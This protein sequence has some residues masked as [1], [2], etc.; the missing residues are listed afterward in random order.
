M[1]GLAGVRDGVEDPA[2]DA[3]PHVVGADV[4]GRGRAWALDRGSTRESA[5]PYRSCPAWSHARSSSVTSRPRPSRRSTIPPAPN[6]SIGR[7]VRGVDREQ[8]RSDREEEARLGAVAGVPVDHPAIDAR[9]PRALGV[10]RKRIEDPPRRGRLLR[11]APAA[12]IADWSR[13]ASPRTTIGLHWICVRPSRASPV[14]YV[15][16]TCSRATLAAVICFSGECCR[17][18]ASPPCAGQSR[19]GRPLPP[20]TFTAYRRPGHDDRQDDRPRDDRNRAAP[21]FRRR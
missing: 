5:D 10:V 7:P 19:S 11:R 17:C 8:P 16:A 15:H 3:G 2:D 13:T 12:S 9:R 14:R 20:A 4:A 1:P 21:A 6:P 18:P